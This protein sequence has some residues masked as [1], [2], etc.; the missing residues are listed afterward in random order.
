MSATVK[1]LA[2]ETIRARL[3]AL[4]CNWDVREVREDDATPDAG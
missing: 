1:A 2:I 4:D 3:H